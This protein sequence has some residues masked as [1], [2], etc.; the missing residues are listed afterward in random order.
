MT[1]PINPDIN[2]IVKDII[3][4]Q[5][6]MPFAHVSIE[7]DIRDDLGADSLHVIEI[8]MSL[9]TEFDIEIPDDDMEKVKTVEDIVKYI[10]G[11]MKQCK[12]NSGLQKQKGSETKE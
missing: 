7:N 9:E 5:M 4:D 11:R 12:K 8:I 6:S 2:Y 10:E 3:A 1:C